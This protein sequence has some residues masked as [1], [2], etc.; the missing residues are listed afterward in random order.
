MQQS[1]NTVQYRKLLIIINKTKYT[2][3]EVPMLRKYAFIFDENSQF[4]L[5]NKTLI[6]EFKHLA[7]MSKLEAT[8]KLREHYKKYVTSLFEK[9][10][11]KTGDEYNYPV[12]LK[13]NYHHLK[14]YAK[15]TM[16]TGSYNQYLANVKNVNSAKKYLDELP[17]K[18]F[19]L[20]AENRLTQEIISVIGNINEN[21]ASEHNR[22]FG[23]YKFDSLLHS[24]VRN[25]VTETI[26]LLLAAGADVNAYKPSYNYKDKRSA[27]VN[28]TPL[29]IAI[30]ADNV[31]VARL[32]LENGALINML[33]Y[34]STSNKQLITAKVSS[35]E[36]SALLSAYYK[37][38]L[39]ADI[40]NGS[41]HLGFTE[42]FLMRE[43]QQLETRVD[44]LS[45]RLNMLEQSIL[46]MNQV[47]IPPPPF[48]HVGN[49]FFSPRASANDL[50]GSEPPEKKHRTLRPGEGID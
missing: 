31:A 16:F 45:A 29:G 1:H 21:F 8:P 43:N 22:D 40:Q 23:I 24:A 46:K 42:Q 32:L 18:A 13:N 48:V 38:Q 3:P 28:T 35:P 44:E 50:A 6:T 33:E 41:L 10:L 12:F 36:M 49:S 25:A 15:S 39:A 27:T 4:Y 47:N 37:I 17:K 34:R 7:N 11:T 9:S 14:S 30:E 2:K 19:R 20:A 5:E 26:K